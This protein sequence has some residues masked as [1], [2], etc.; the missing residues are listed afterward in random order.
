MNNINTNIE[1][2]PKICGIV[3]L[4]GAVVSAISLFTIV[5]YAIRGESPLTFALLLRNLAC[6]AGFAVIGV[7]IFTERHHLF[8][9]GLFT[10]AA[11]FV[12][13]AYFPLNWIRQNTKY[14][15]S[16][17][18]GF[19][20][21]NLILLICYLSALTGF[22]LMG[23]LFS[24]KQVGQAQ[25]MGTIATICIAVY[26]VI[27]VG[28]AMYFMKDN[29]VTLWPYLSSYITGSSALTVVGAIGTL[30]MPSAFPEEIQ[31]A[32]MRNSSSIN[33]V[34]TQSEQ[35]V[36]AVLGNMNV[37]DDDAFALLRKYKQLLDMGVITQEEFDLKK[38]ELL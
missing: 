20:E 13:D 36:S 28:Y 37:I 35:N 1:S 8:K 4:L 10:V 3:I 19:K 21:G 5:R 9:I 24:N 12:V 22:L 25:K 7:G 2:K 17:T 6:V 38:K 16:L 15:G 30:L 32:E 26:I 23:I 27:A 11:A 29:Y 31:Q 18:G 33:H 14:Y 34:I